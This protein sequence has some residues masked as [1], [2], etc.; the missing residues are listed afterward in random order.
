[1]LPFC[2]AV[3]KSSQVVTRLMNS[4]PESGQRDRQ[5]INCKKVEICTE[6]GKHDKKHDYCSRHL[7]TT[8]SIPT[9][10]TVR[11]CV[12]L[13]LSGLKRRS[14]GLEVR[15]IQVRSPDHDLFC[16]SFYYSVGATCWQGCRELVV[17]KLDDSIGK[18]L[19]NEAVI[20]MSPCTGE[21]II[22]LKLNPWALPIVNFA[23]ISTQDIPGDCLKVYLINAGV[24]R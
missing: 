20:L 15:E 19:S 2:K 8:F 14:V 23:Q 21:I 22:P 6:K 4:N 24:I 1:M 10:N 5:A 13:W 7:A 16:F 18:I 11:L 12:L 9:L 3:Q 17:K